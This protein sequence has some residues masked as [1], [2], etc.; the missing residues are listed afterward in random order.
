LGEPLINFRRGDG[1][2]LLA[3]EPY[4]LRTVALESTE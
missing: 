4:P 3:L 2:R 1:L